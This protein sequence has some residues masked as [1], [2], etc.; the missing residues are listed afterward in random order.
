[1]ALILL[2]FPCGSMVHIHLFCM[3]RVVSR[4]NGPTEKDV[5]NVMEGPFEAIGVPPMDFDESTPGKFD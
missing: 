3:M 5:R 4:S 1:M 2:R